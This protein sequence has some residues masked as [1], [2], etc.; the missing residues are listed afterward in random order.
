MMPRYLNPK[1][2]SLDHEV[3]KKIIEG[4]SLA[5]DNLVPHKAYTLRKIIETVSP[6]WWEY[7]DFYNVR[8]AGV[9]FRKLVESGEFPQYR[10]KNPEQYSSPKKY[11]FLGNKNE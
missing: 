7:I 10:L 11:I 5:T 1:G 3:M 6:D 4:A 2:L 8:S 9:T